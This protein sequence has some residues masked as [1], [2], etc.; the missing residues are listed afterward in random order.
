MPGRQRS[1]P[2]PPRARSS[3][4]GRD[5]SAIEKELRRL[6][7]LKTKAEYDPDEIPVSVAKKA[8]E[9]ADRCVTVARR[10]SAS[11]E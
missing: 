3:E 1:S 10:V 5:G 9:R 8:V 6:L 7:P 11:R 2:E 4:A